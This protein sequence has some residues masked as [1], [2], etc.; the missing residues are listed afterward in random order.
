MSRTI[1]CIAGDGWALDDI[2]V[3]QYFPPNWHTSAGFLVSQDISHDFLQRA[4]CCF[5]TEWCQTRLSNEQMQD[6]SKDIPCYK[7]RRY[8][9][10]GIEMFVCL[11]T[12]LNLV[13]FTYVTVQTFLLTRRVPF[14][15]EIEDVAKLKWL[16]QYLP[17]RLVVPLV[18]ASWVS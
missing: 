14:Q 4:Q 8:L 7:Q 5:D 15:D 16:F 1:R 2:K 17:L 11:A 6:C 10:R 18:C 3:F 9:I 12:L 13:K